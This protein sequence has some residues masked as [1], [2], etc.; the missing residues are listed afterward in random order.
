MKCLGQAFSLEGFGAWGVPEGSVMGQ[1]VPNWAFLAFVGQLFGPSAQ[2]LLGGW[3]WMPWTW[4][5]SSGWS[6]S[7]GYLLGLGFR[8]RKVRAWAGLGHA[9]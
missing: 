2:A 5:A 4:S 7:Q 6:G 9:V 8:V 1:K 3:I